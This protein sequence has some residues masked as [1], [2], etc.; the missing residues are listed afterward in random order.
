MSSK[1]NLIYPEPAALLLMCLLLIT[2]PL[3]VSASAPQVSVTFE[4]RVESWLRQTGYDYKR[5]KAN[6]WYITL[7]GKQLRQIRV[8]VGAG[9]TSIAVGAVVVPKQRLRVTMDSMYKMMKL[10]YD[11]NYVRVCIDPD[12]DLLVMAQVEER[13]LDAQEFKKTIDRIAAAADRTYGEVQA[14]INTQ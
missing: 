12:D 9:P 11:L 8:L 2:L 1:A 5:V 6:S 3:R 4:A 14:F 10:S 13:S 7:T